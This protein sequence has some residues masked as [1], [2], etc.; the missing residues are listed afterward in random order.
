MFSVGGT[1]ACWSIS[2][3][4]TIPPSKS[5]CIYHI[6]GK[7]LLSS[8]FIIP[9]LVLP[10]CFLSSFQTNTRSSHFSDAK[11]VKLCVV[12]DR[13]PIPPPPPLFIL[14]KSLFC[15]RMLLNFLEGSCKLGRDVIQFLV[16]E[17]ELHRVSDLIIGLA[18]T[19]ISDAGQRHQKK[20]SRV[21]K[22]KRLK[23]PTNVIDA[24]SAILGLHP[25]ILAH[26]RNKPEIKM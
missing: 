11:F 22:K 14:Q 13:L 21:L 9:F 1:W 6:V 18:T 17:V 2:L 19:F 12:W 23:L 20:V 5:L 15:V 26:S 3:C 8:I 7:H 16:L 4:L 10:V 24:S 25:E